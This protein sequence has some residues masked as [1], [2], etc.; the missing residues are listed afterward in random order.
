MRPIG[1]NLIVKPAEIVELDIDVTVELFD[2]LKQG[3]IDAAIRA[4][5]DNSFFIG[6]DFV[7]SDLIRKCHI[8]GVYRVDTDFSDVIVSE[9]Q[10]VKINSLNLN[11]VEASL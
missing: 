3:E 9:K 6:Q 10:I 8:D 2:M 5:F 7:R 4:N 11:Y 1:D